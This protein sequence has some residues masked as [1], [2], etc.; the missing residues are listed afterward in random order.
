MFHL[1][2]IKFTSSFES[3][4]DG[5]HSS[6]VKVKFS[7]SSSVLLL[8][9]Q[10]EEGQLQFVV[11]KAVLQTKL[12]T[13]RLNSATPNKTL[14]QHHRWQHSNSNILGREQEQEQEQQPSTTRRRT[15]KAIC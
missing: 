9:T 6:G 13:N 15:F 5:K 8:G 11:L 3:I 7:S 10:T 14:P 2:T 1:L 12:K 4:S